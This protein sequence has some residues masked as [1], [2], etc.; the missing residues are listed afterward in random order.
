MQAVF[1]RKKKPV[2]NKAPK[3]KEKQNTVP[4]RARDCLDDL[5]CS[6]QSMGSLLSQQFG[7]QQS[8]LCLSPQYKI[9]R[10]QQSPLKTPPS[11]PL[12]GFSQL[13]LPFTQPSPSQAGDNDMQTILS[14]VSSRVGKSIAK[15]EGREQ[16]TREEIANLVQSLTATRASIDKLIM[17]SLVR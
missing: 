1:M 13:S 5:L 8:T 15:L 3:E 10:T 4:K 2:L 17:E 14:I 6:Q 7:S 12:E 11:S 9:A 16:L